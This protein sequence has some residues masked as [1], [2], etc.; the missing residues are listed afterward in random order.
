V[1]TF[2]TERL[3]LRPFEAG[4]WRALQGYVSQEAVTRYDFEYPTSDEGCQGLVAYFG[5]QAGYWAVCLREGGRLIGHLVCT[6]KAPEELR[7]WDLGFV[8]DPAYHGQGYA[9]EAC[10][11][12]LAYVFGELGAHR[13]EAGCHPD[14]APSWRLLERLGLRREAHFRKN[15]FLRRAADGTP[16]WTDGYVYGMLEEE[17]AEA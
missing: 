15:G 8:F 17:W 7:T 12:V 16:I 11:R 10:R 5:A 4:D 2:V 1:A 14:N 3:I 6:P 9:T 13:V